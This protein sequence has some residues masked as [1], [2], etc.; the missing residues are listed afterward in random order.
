MLKSP[1]DTVRI[2][3]EVE[4]VIIVTAFI[5]IRELIFLF[6]YLFLQNDTVTQLSC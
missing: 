4:P 3:P 6:I 5:L 1:F 2:T